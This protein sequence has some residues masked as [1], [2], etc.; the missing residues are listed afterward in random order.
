MIYLA[1]WL[2]RRISY[3]ITLVKPMSRCAWNQLGRGP[4]HPSDGFRRKGVQDARR[5]LRMAAPGHR[6]RWVSAG[7]STQA[8]RGQF[9]TSHRLRV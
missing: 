3:V 9:K 1:L 7:T 5:W 2:I 6:V 8:T 4:A